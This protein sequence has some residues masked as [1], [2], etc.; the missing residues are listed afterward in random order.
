MKFEILWNLSTRTKFIG[1]KIVEKTFENRVEE[2][3]SFR[4]S[5]SLIDCGMNTLES[6]FNRTIKSQFALH[7]KKLSTLFPTVQIKHEKS[8]N[9]VV[10]NVITPQNTFKSPLSVHSINP[11]KA[12]TWENI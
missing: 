11:K 10:H 1:F 3:V 2:S 4:H 8:E 7:Q 9:Y 6:P 5:N 12:Q